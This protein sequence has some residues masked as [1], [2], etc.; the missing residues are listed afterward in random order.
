MHLAL[1][2]SRSQDFGWQ[3]RTV[4]RPPLWKRVAMWFGLV[5]A[6]ALVTA[7][8]ASLVTP[9]LPYRLARAIQHQFAPRRPL[10]ALIVSDYVRD[11]REATIWDRPPLIFPPTVSYFRSH[12][13][14]FDPR[15]DHPYRK[16]RFQLWVPELVHETPVYAGLP[17]EVAG[18]IRDANILGPPILSRRCLETGHNVATC[19]KHARVEWVVQL[20]GITVEH[21]GLVY[22]RVTEPIRQHLHAGQIVTASGLVLA[23]GPIGLQNGQRDQAVYMVCEAIQRPRGV[24]GRIAHSIE[25]HPRRWAAFL[26]KYG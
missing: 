1:K 12:F 15:R 24:F 9:G 17:V 4:P 16:T 6:T 19:A 11:T 10:S 14:A 20:G 2:R 26:K 5:S 21:S 8:V 23:A 7:L 13:A 18:A 22:C 3:A 25:N